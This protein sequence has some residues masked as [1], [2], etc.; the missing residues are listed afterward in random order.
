M[1]TSPEAISWENRLIS[2]VITDCHPQEIEKV[3]E[4]ANRAIAVQSA[5]L[6]KVVR[7]QI[8]VKTN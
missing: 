5:S 3:R 4:S 8:K 6:E 1:E 2:V 7:Q